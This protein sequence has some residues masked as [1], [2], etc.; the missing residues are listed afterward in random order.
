MANLAM[1]RRRYLHRDSCLILALALLCG[2]DRRDDGEAEMVAFA[3]VSDQRLVQA[4]SEPAQWMTHGGTYE[5]QRYSRLTQINRENVGQ[6]GL[7][8]YAD[9]DTNLQ[10]EGTPLFIDGVIY[11]STAWSKVYALDAATGRDD[12]KVPGEWARHTCCGVVNRG[13]AAYDGKIFVGTLDG[14]LV[15][16]DAATGNEVWSVNTIDRDKPYTITGAPRIASR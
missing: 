1:P 16:L 3:R 13:V 10:Q 14:W 6:L 2:C 4:A 5:E 11:V 15:A 9:Y 7:V 12:P 8:W